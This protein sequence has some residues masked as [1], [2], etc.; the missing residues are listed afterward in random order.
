MYF[1]SILVQTRAEGTKCSHNKKDPNIFK[2]KLP[3]AQIS[4]CRFE[5]M[6]E[7]NLGKFRYKGLKI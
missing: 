3:I 6:T 4:L 7:P 1:Y 5:F 2:P